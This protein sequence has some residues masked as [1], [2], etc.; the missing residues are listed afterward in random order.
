MI[1]HDVDYE[2]HAPTCH[3]AANNLA[4]PHV[5]RRY[6]GGIPGKVGLPLLNDDLLFA[7]KPG[8]NGLAVLSRQRRKKY[9]DIFRHR[10]IGEV[11]V[12]VG[13]LE[14]VKRVLASEH[15]LVEGGARTHFCPSNLVFASTYTT[16]TGRLSSRAG[17]AVRVLP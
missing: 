7:L 12:A 11:A 1:V 3:Q 14:N 15:V 9:G 8:R 10:F 17:S 6:K 16:C 4:C 2:L 5:L 13:G